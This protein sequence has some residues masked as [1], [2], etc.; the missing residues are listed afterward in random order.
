V[1]SKINKPVRVGAV[2]SDKNKERPLY[3]KWFTYRNEK[4]PILKIISAWG[5]REGIADEYYFHVET[6]KG[7]YI[8]KFHDKDLRWV[9][10][11]QNDN[12]CAG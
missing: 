12:V 3:P 9:L 4:F 10:H 5:V 11:S 2:F 6:P 1:G 8:L 7:R